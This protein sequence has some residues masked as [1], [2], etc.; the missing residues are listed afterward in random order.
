[1]QEA[2]C[3]TCLLY[4]W[5]QHAIHCYLSMGWYPWG[6]I[7]I[8][9]TFSQGIYLCFHDISPLCRALERYPSNGRLL[10]AYGRF[11]EYVVND[12]W[13]ASKYYQMAVKEGLTE[14]MLALA[15]NTEALELAMGPVDERQDGVLII[16]AEGTI[17]MTNAVSS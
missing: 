7:S 4:L 11:E 16:N 1:M 2:V 12:P 15:G 10:K 13:T 8:A 3:K 14:S 6:I 5:T 17:L 9:D